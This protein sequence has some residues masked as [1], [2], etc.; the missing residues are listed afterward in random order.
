MR[1]AR[2]ATA[3]LCILLHNSQTKSPA[4]TSTTAPSGVCSVREF[5]AAIPYA[6]AAESKRTR[7]ITA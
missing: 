3:P 2:L 7:C 1:K 5:S 4:R 6:V